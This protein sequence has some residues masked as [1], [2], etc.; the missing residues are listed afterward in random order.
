[1]KYKDHIIVTTDKGVALVVIDKVE[2]ITRC[3]V[4][5]QDSSVYQHLSKDTSPTF[6]EELNK[7]LQDCKN[8]NFISERE[9]TQLRP[10]GSNSLAARFYGL[11]IVHKNNIPMCSMVSVCGTAA[12]NTAK[13]INTFL[14]NYC[15]KMSSFV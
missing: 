7:F 4:F 2:Y 11:S 3:E 1:M 10:R 12:Y 15:G 9:F 8:N 6:H 14:Q 5:L 13:F